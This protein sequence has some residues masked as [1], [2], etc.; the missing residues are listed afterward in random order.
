MSLPSIN[1]SLL[2]SGRREYGVLV[3]LF[4]RAPS[5]N[6]Y[7]GTHKVRSVG[8]W[9]LLQS[10]WT[11]RANSLSVARFIPTLNPE[12]PSFFMLLL[13]SA[14]Y[15]SPLWG[16]GARGLVI[17]HTFR[18]SGAVKRLVRRRLAVALTI[19]LVDGFLWDLYRNRYPLP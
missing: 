12:E 2:W 7:I 14:M 1:I 3:L 15:L 9:E 18:P 19:R 11:H 4:T 17:L 16:L 6:F 13:L 5:R 8:Y 10:I